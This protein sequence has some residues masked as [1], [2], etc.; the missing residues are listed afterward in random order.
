MKTAIILV[1]V[2]LAVSAEA[3]MTL[4]A[5]MTAEGGHDI[6]LCTKYGEVWGF[7][8]DQQRP[9]IEIGKVVPSG[10]AYV[11]GYLSYWSSTK[12]LYLEP[13]GLFVKDF[14]NVRLRAKG[15]AYLP[16]NGGKVAVGSDEISLTYKVSPKVRIGA[17]AHF[18]K[19]EG[20]DALK[21]VGGQLEWIADERTSMILRATEGDLAQVRL[22]VC[23]CF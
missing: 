10:D 21:A 13:F 4:V 19:A 16:L 3:G 7:S 22:T 9:T 23:R 14:G 2:V 12:E 5:R 15:F 8:L 1:L 17:I 6:G 20:E 11:G 18:W